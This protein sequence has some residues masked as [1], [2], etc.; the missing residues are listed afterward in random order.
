MIGKVPSGRMSPGQMMLWVVG[1]GDFPESWKGLEI[2]EGL[3]S[4]A[5]VVDQVADRRKGT[6]LKQYG[7]HEVG[8]QINKKTT[9]TVGG[10]VGSLTRYVR[11]YK[12]R[13]VWINGSVVDTRNVLCSPI[14][15]HRGRFGKCR[16]AVIVFVNGSIAKLGI[17]PGEWLVRVRVAVCRIAGLCWGA[18]DVRICL[19]IA[20]GWQPIT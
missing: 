15:W 19:R 3:R 18:W 17:I 5:A 12:V 13:R 1:H 6:S 10:N 2:D 16:L 11:S 7:R 4:E 8:R 20:R 14:S 9:R